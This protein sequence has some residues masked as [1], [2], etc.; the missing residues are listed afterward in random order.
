MPKVLISDKMS[1]KAEEIFK[2]NKIDVDV[3]TG[4]DEAGLCK[5]IGGQERW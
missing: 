4:L 2:K 1:A 5:I 3:I